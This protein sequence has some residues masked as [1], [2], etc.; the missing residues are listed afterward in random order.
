[1]V[2]FLVI[3]RER[4]RFLPAYSQE[5]KDLKL[6]ILIPKNQMGGPASKYRYNEF[7]VR[8]AHRQYYLYHNMLND[9]G[10]QVYPKFYMEGKFNKWLEEESSQW[11]PAEYYY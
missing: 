10:F 11:A 8:M 5:G 7:S 4:R 6:I 1:M 2:V 9:F 3:K